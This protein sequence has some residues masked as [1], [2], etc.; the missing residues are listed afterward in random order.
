MSKQIFVNLPVKDLKRS[1]AFYEAIGFRNNPQF[2]DDAGA[3]MVVSD[4]IFVMLLTHEKFR[5]FS[6]KRII[7][8]RTEAGVLI[9]IST[10][11]NDELNTFVGQALEAGG[12][13]YRDPQDLGFMQLRCFED[14]D[15]NNWEV[16]YVDMSK[17]PAPIS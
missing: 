17:F 5:Q 8:A 13:E 1:M 10:A 11:S 14:P 7:D 2:S 4:I 15:G 3:C 6:S 16:T 9:S 12:R